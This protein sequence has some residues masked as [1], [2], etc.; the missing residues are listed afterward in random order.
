MDKDILKTA[1]QHVAEAMDSAIGNI[2]DVP[3]SNEPS[4]FLK[5]YLSVED[6]TVQDNVDYVEPMQD[7]YQKAI[8]Y[9]EHHSIMQMFQVNFFCRAVANKLS[10]TALLN[11][12]TDRTAAHTP[13]QR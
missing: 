7:P 10:L 5:Q 8:M 2:G 4:D 12:F 3:K 1:L 9:L 11:L 13:L 6:T